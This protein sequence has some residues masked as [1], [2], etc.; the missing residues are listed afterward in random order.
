[1][2]N[3]KTS[4]SYPRPPQA[5]DVVPGQQNLFDQTALVPDPTVE[6]QR[7]AAVNDRLTRAEC[8]ARNLLRA[9]D[10]ARTLQERG[11]TLPDVAEALGLP[12]PVDRVTRPLKPWRLRRDSNM[13]VIATMLEDAGRN[14]VS[15]DDMVDRLRSLGRLATANDP[16]RSV[17]WTVS[18]LRKRTKF[19]FRGLQDKG[20]RWYAY[21]RFDTWRN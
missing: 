20:G 1:M 9:I 21:G 16:R 2:H 3:K 13:D 8:D 11:H 4:K 19:A 7:R 10:I 5:S 15:E 14:G 12:S 6:R 17:H 18:E